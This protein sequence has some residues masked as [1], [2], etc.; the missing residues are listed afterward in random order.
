MSGR[1][2]IILRHV[3][4]CDNFDHT[5]NLLCP[6]RVNRLHI[7]VS[8]RGMELLRHICISVTQIIRILCTAG[9]FLKCIYTFHALTD[10]MVFP[11]S[12]LFCHML[13]S[14]FPSLSHIWPGSHAHPPDRSY[15]P[16]CS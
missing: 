4:T 7:P 13:T 11:D 8:N 14:R 16:V 5:W 10:H 12:I 6:G 15:A 9:Y 2:E 3:K 1:R